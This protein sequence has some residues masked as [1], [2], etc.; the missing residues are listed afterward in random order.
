VT[1]VNIVNVPV[2]VHSKPRPGFRQ[3][4]KPAR[5]PAADAVGPTGPTQTR[6][7]A[8]TV[9]RDELRSRRTHIVLLRAFGLSC[10]LAS[11][12]L[13]QSNQ[14]FVQDPGLSPSRTAS[15]SFLTAK[16]GFVTVTPFHVK[17]SS[18][19]SERRRRQPASAAAER[20][21][22]SQMLSR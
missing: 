22:A 13:I 16:N 7:A 11:M 5:T 8:F 6:S 9:L 21:T 12:D 4:A 3:D 18:K 15:S 1:V 20:I 19:S 14:V 17:P 2:P 10:S